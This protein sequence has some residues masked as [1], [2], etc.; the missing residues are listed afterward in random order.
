MDDAAQQAGPAARSYRPE[1][2]LGGFEQE[3]ARLDHQAALTWAHEW[4]ILRPLA[5]SGGGAVLDAGCG[6]GAVTAELS[7]ALPGTRIVGL[8][9]HPGLLERAG[10][11][12]TGG[13][14]PELLLGDVGD[15][16]FADE[17]FDLVLSRYVFQHL[18]EPIGVARELRRVLRPGGHLAVIDVDAGLWGTA[19]PDLSGFSEEAYRALGAT[20]SA[21][22]GDRLIARRLPR[23]LRDAG[24]TDVTVQPF[25]YTSDEVGLAALAPQLSPERLL[26]LVERGTL[27]LTAYLRAMTAWQNF[28]ARDGFVLLLGF[29]VVG[30]R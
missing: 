16:P 14:E 4:R 10:A 23:I 28:V 20:Q 22:G 27:S 7:A 1:E 8:D 29:A 30:R 19:E 21:D 9:A 11:R 5:P 17:T 12:G 3:V 13:P 18:P 2:E 15:T 24:F 25:A 6:N 26:P